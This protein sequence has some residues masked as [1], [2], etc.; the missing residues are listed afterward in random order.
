MHQLRE[1]T[2]LRHLGTLKMPIAE[3]KS[4]VAADPY[5][6]RSDAMTGLWCRRQVTF[7]GTG[8]SSPGISRT[9]QGSR[10]S[11][12]TSRHSPAGTTT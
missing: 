1:A 6:A 11:R 3:I 5:A 10:K 9:T 8:Q 7:S 12:T 2:L 4:F